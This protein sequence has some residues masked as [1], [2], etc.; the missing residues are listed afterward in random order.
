MSLFKIKTLVNWLV[1]RLIRPHRGGHGIHSPFLYQ[2]V[3]QVLYNKLVNK[4]A[5]KETKNLSER[6]KTKYGR[7][8]Y[9]MSRYFRP[10][11][12][13]VVG[14]N[15]AAAYFKAGISNT[16][17]I[18]IEADNLYGNRLQSA[19][20]EVKTFD[21]L[22]VDCNVMNDDVMSVFFQSSLYSGNSSVIIFDNICANEGVWKA[23]QEICSSEQ[24]SVSLD[25]FT[26]G[27][28]FFNEKLKKQH[29]RLYY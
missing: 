13:V 21:F 27:I 4:S 17:I 24:V 1:Y 19:L 7:L 10:K 14:T 12:I 9:K 6:Y 8:F 26:I 20:D 15:S 23:W 5:R 16:N 28:V 3:N 2:F 25:L 18:E 22:Y 11:T 29:F